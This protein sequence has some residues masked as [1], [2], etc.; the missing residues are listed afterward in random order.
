MNVRRYGVAPCTSALESCSSRAPSP[1]G[2]RTKIAGR[3]LSTALF[4]CVANAAH[5][6]VTV[7]PHG[8]Y[9]T[10]GD[11]ITAALMARDND[12]RVEVKLCNDIHGFVYICPYVENVSFILSQNQN[13]RMTG[14]WHSDFQTRYPYGTRSMI[15]GSGA[16]RPVFE[17]MLYYNAAVT[18]TGF[19]ID[20]TSTAPDS[21]TRGIFLQAY[22][23]SQ[24]DIVDNAIH[25]FALQQSGDGGAAL[26]AQAY[27]QATITFDGNTVSSNSTFGI[28]LN[29][30]YGGAVDLYALGNAT[31]IDFG[32]NTLSGNTISNPNNGVCHGG[33][34]FARSAASGSVINLGANIYSGNG[35]YA[36]TNGATGDAVEL[37]ATD[38]ATIVLRD[39][40][41]KN[42][43]V[44]ND[45]GVYEVFM[46]AENG[47]AIVGGNGVVTRGTWGGLY[48][49]TD[50][51]SQVTLLNFTI[52][53]NPVLGY[54]GY[55]AG[56]QLWNTILWNDGAP[57]QLDAGATF[58]FCL[59]ASD[60]LFLNSSAGDYRLSSGSPA[61]NAG[62]NA[63]VS[64]PWDKDID[65]NPR[66]YL[67]DGVGIVDIGA[68]EFVQYDRIFLSKFDPPP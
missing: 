67:G 51:S 43:N 55:G 31:T 10:I 57:F 24:A 53:D 63:I 41:W 1:R 48:A 39:E 46:H 25:N 47:G 4:A 16:N 26:D 62:Y 35:Q 6:Y 21:Q 23:E 44:P 66:P 40:V 29:G 12:L 34:L 30:I 2:S 5:G 60:P 18:I 49:Q 65:L 64:P 37:D 19:D 28:D 3:C 8:T 20:G 42:N 36:C 15:K 14:E 32:G 17:V 59:Y 54:H 68:H 9:N 58:A 7:G 56:T 45:P 33:A 61:I 11:G 27:S 13:L 52:A 50:T 22:S 38:G